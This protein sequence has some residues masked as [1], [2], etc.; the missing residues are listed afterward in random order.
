[1]RYLLALGLR[2]AS[3]ASDAGRPEAHRRSR[4]AVIATLASLAMLLFAVSTAQALVRQNTFGSAGS[5]DGQFATPVGVAVDQSNGSIYVDDA[6]QA[7]V[8]KFNAAGTFQRAW[9]W[10]VA[11]GNSQFETCTSNC[12]SGQFGN[13][14]GQFGTPTSIAVDST[15]HDVYVGD[16]TFQR[17]QKFSANGAFLSTIDGTTTTQGAF[18]G[19][20][21]V[22]VDQSGNL[23]T[24]DRITGNIDEFDN[25]GAFV[26]QWNDN[27]GTTANGP[28]AV[29]STNNAVYLLSPQNN[30][31]K[32]SLTGTGR[33][34]ITSTFA[35]ATMNVDPTTGDLYVADTSNGNQFLVFDTT[36]TQTDSFPATAVTL[37]GGVAVRGSTSQLSVSDQSN[38]NVGQFVPAVPGP[39]VVDSQSASDVT[40]DSATLNAEV[41]PFGNDTTCTFQYVDD[42]TFQATTWAD[43]TS[44]ACSPADLGSTFTD[45]AAT[46]DIAGLTHGT[47]YHFRVVA[48]N[49][50]DTTD[51]PDT[52]FPTLA[53]PA[54]DSESAANVTDTTATLKAQIN[55]N[56]GDATYQFQFGTTTAYTGGTVPANPVDLGSGTSDVAASVDLTGLTP[57]T[58]YHFRVVVNGTVNGADQTFHTFAT[59]ASTGLPDGRGLEMV[60]PADKDNGEIYVRGGQIFGA[61][62]AATNGDAINFLSFNGFPGSVFDGSF[63]LSSRAAA[64]WNTA[65]LIPP[66]ST[67]AGLLCATAGPQMMAY[68]EI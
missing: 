30:V 17:V 18:Q 15:S 32:W 26:Q 33:T 28:I 61:P 51:G 47:I 8:E 7:R 14:D 63:Y 45:Q 20:A 56:G 50:T 64:N 27:Y 13:G 42:A 67:E 10:G 66:Q 1:M 34:T 22:A 19:L 23:W 46:A 21:G 5:G 11:D 9:G 58:T 24:D 12:Q 37:F 39:P 3:G 44:V 53:D 55:P 57:N 43:A 16:S 31:D 25:T 48:T 38:N 6:N 41:N 52:T 60:T 2:A 65:N 54:I 40:R 59:S 36:G 35:V 68:S 62:Q 29:D 49:G 4:L